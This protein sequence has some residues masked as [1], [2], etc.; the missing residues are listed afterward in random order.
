[1]Q[2]AFK[3]VF[4]FFP[5]VMRTAFI[6]SPFDLD[7]WHQNLATWSRSSVDWGKGDV[8]LMSAY[9]SNLNG[10]NFCTLVHGATAARYFG[11]EVVDQCFE[12]VKLADIDQHLKATIIMIKKL[13]DQP[14]EFSAKDVEATLNTDV[15]VSALEHAILIAMTYNIMN[16]LSDA[17]GADIPKDKVETAARI[18]NMQGQRPLKNRVKDGKSI[19]Y[20]GS[21]PEELSKLKYAVLS[22]PGTIEPIVRRAIEARVASSTGAIRT[23]YDLSSDL[24]KYVD[25]VGKHAP[26]IL[27]ED[28]QQLKDHGW[29]EEQIFE[30]TFAAAAGA[31]F[32]IQEIGWNKIAELESR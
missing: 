32:A 27:D 19:P 5:D 4:G 24:Y 17:L 18:M 28:I 1:M 25:K 11:R 6:D 9:V 7:I 16:R 12:D 26:D 2:T 20:S 23:K 13:V 21:E 30:I 14:T 29:T 3:T 15:T 22:G 10:C 8:E 31:G